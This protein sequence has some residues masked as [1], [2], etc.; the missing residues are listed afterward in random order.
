[1]K[2]IF[3]LLLAAMCMTTATTAT[4][5]TPENMNTEKTQPRVVNN[6]NVDSTTVEFCQVARVTVSNGQTMV[7]IGIDL[8][9]G[10]LTEPAKKTSYLVNAET[11]TTYKYKSAIGY[12]AKEL[13]EV[14]GIKYVTLVFKAIDANVKYL[15]LVTPD[16]IFYGIDITQ[17]GEGKILYNAKTRAMDKLK[18]ELPAGFGVE[19]TGN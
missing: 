13:K 19:E 17:D 16:Y 11:G 2:K 7:T 4:A 8:T 12:K 5:A 3:Y 14:D 15:D 18:K 6:P 1:M 9:K 10:N